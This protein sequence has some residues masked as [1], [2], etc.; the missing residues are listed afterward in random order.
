MSLATGEVL[1]AG[2]ARGQEPPYTTRMVLTASCTVV[3]VVSHI[4]PLFLQQ[5][6]MAQMVLL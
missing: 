5:V 1:V 2:S 3:V 4:E 6:E